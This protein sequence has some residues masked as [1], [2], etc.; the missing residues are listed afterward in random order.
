MVSETMKRMLKNLSDRLNDASDMIS[1]MSFDDDDLNGTT[2]ILTLCDDLADFIDNYLGSKSADGI[3]LS[4]RLLSNCIGKEIYSITGYQIDHDKC[5][6]ISLSES[7]VYLYTGYGVMIGSSDS[8]F[9]S[10]AD[11]QKHYWELY[12]DSSFPGRSDLSFEDALMLDLDYKSTNFKTDTYVYE[13]DFAGKTISLS[14]TGNI[15][16]RGSEE[17]DQIIWDAIC[18]AMRGE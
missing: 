6:S 17:R 10:L 18:N 1:D 15:F 8:C 12:H 2:G 13:F 11:A 5:T 16:C 7:D 4:N 9:L 14:V 3:L